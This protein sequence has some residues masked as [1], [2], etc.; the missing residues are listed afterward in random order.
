MPKKSEMNVIEWVL[1]R[2]LQNAGKKPMQYAT[3]APA[4]AFLFACARF[5]GSGTAYPETSMLSD[6]YSNYSMDPYLLIKTDIS[7]KAQT[8]RAMYIPFS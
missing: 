7:I 2:L 8:I 1:S 5:M 3:V 6:L 4:I